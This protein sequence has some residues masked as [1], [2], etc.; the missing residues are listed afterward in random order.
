MAD[1]SA[2][3]W[4][5]LADRELIVHNDASVLFVLSESGLVFKVKIVRGVEGQKRAIVCRCDL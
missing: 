1:S 4:N 5:G 3:T 2:V